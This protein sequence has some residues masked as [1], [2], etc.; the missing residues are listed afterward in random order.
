DATT[1]SA[2]SRC[3]IP[4]MRPRRS[5]PRLC[6][7]PY[8]AA[9]PERV[10]NMADAA[11][12]QK[13]PYHLVDPSPWPA[14]GATGALLLALGAALGM[15]PDLFGTGAV[16]RVVKQVEWWVVA[17]GLLIILATM[18]WWWSDV[19]AES[20]K[21]HTAVVQL[22]LRCGMI[23]FIASEVLF[24]AAFFWAFFDAALFPGSPEMPTRAEVTGRVLPPQGLSVI[25]ALHP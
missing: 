19:I 1:T 23:L 21:Y 20:R 24:F 8:P 11:H 7:A 25:A 13:H 15:H 6:W 18:F 10:E 4:S 5:A 2:P 14:V 9:D 16:E 12:T 17:P 22:G 3:P